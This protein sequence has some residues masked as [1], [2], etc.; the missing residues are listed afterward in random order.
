MAR[1]AVFFFVAFLLST[2]IAFWPTYF[3][4]MEQM[5]SWRVHAHGAFLFAW[6]L[7]LIAQGWLI[8]NRRGAW[9]RALGKV[10]YVLAPLVVISALVLE[11]DVVVKAAGKYN[12]ETLYFAYVIVALLTLFVLSY[13]L[14]IVH[15][16]TPALH[17]RYM[18][19]T[20]L[21]MVD[22]V[23]ARIVDVR[24]GISFGP[25]QMITY[26]L[27]DAILLWLAFNDR[28]TPNRV[29]AKMLAAFVVIQVSTFFLYKAA[30]WPDVVAWFALLP[31][32]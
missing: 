13:V 5:A 11:H 20:A 1:N 10:S 3:T 4:R 24:L 25:G 32:P 15:R 23:F 28:N 8:R 7:L 27:V 9:H 17:M 2:L 30:W 14:G 31:M 19:C 6:L 22:P 12:D 29:F 16:R 26:A 18:I 21:T